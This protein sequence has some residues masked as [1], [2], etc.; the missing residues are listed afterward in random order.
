MNRVEFPLQLRFDTDFGR[1]LSGPEVAPHHHPSNTQLETELGG[2]T[3]IDTRR[4]NQRQTQIHFSA[5]PDQQDGAR[6]SFNLAL[7]PHQRWTL[8]I[9][10]KWIV[11]GRSSPAETN[12]N[13]RGHRTPVR[14]AMDT[15]NTNACHREPGPRGRAYMRAVRDLGALEIA[16][17]TGYPIPAAGFPWYLAIFG[18]DRDRELATLILDQRHARGTLRPWAPI[19]HLTISVSRRGTREDRSRDPFWRTGDFRYLP[20]SRYYGSVDSTPLWLICSV[21]IYDGRLTFRC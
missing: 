16:L 11:P 20:H 15:S 9:D 8:E 6:V 14:P 1:D 3:F 10:V 7:D 18:R 21:N 13:R 19:R 5:N 2:I 17:N 4:E 12:T